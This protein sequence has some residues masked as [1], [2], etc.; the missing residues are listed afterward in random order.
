MN[1][2][3]SIISPARAE[4]IARFNAAVIAWDGEAYLAA[5][6]AHAADI[7]RIAAQDSEIAAR[8]ARIARA[9]STYEKAVAGA[10]IEAAA[11]IT[12]MAAIGVTFMVGLGLI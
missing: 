9:E 11:I 1:K 3:S 8:S 10:Y 4:S 7:K 5:S 12:G 2:T 6:V